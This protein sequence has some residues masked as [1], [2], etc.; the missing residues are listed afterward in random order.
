MPLA[1]TTPDPL[2]EH[3]PFIE[4]LLVGPDGEMWVERA[5][6]HPSPPLRAVAHQYGYVRHAWPPSWAAP[7]VFDLFTPEGRYRGTVEVPGD[8]APMAVAGDRVWGVHYDD[9]EVERLVVHEVVEAGAG[10]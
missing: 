3:L 1:L 8:Y 5:D 4:G 9:L 10:R 6:R 2:P 7:R